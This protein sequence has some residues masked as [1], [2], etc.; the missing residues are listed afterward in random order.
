VD[1]I[2]VFGF[3]I[4]AQRDAFSFVRNPYDRM[5]SWFAYHKLNNLPL[6]QTY[7][8]FSDWIKDGAPHHWADH[9]RDSFNPERFGYKY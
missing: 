9:E 3:D 5:V 6:Y 1:Y 4:L 7:N 2:R 8:V